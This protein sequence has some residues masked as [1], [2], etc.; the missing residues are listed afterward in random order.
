ME[1]LK[2]IKE[3]LISI[4]QCQ[5]LDCVDAHEMGEVIDMIKDIEEAIYY[6]TITKAMDEKY[7]EPS[8]MMHY[9]GG[10]S[11]Y[12]PYMEYRP[13]IYRDMDYERMYYTQS[14]GGNGGS[15]AMR[16][17]DMSSNGGSRYYEEMPIRMYDSREGRSGSTRR[18]YMEGKELH[19]D[20]AKQMQEL[21]KYMQELSEDVTE[22]I[23]DASPDEVTLLKQKLTSLVQKLG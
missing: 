3:N 2:S 15:G 11:M 13:E 9:G 22:M 7:N 1:R 23:K 10:R 14:N 5:K 16:N 17:G 20:Q 8:H 6:C 12:T 21:K 4:A 19:H 18:N